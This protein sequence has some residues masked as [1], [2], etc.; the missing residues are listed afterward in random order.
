M[1]S[2]LIFSK[3]NSIFSLIFFLLLSGNY[4]VSGNL[5]TQ[6][7]TTYTESAVYRNRRFRLSYQQVS[8]DE[9]TR[10]CINDN[11]KLAVIDSD[12]V[13]N[14]ITSML[15]TSG[16]MAR[17]Y[18]NPAHVEHGVWFG[19]V[20]DLADKSIGIWSDGS[21]YSRENNFTKWAIREPNTAR[22]NCT[23][24]WRAYFWE[25]DDTY[26]DLHRYY[27]CED[28]DPQSFEVDAVEHLAES[29]LNLTNY[30]EVNAATVNKL[31]GQLDTFLNI[32]DDLTRSAS[33]SV[34]DIIKAVDDIT[35]VYNVSKGEYWHN[36]QNVGIEIVNLRKYDNGLELGE[37][38]TEAGYTKASSVY[39]SK[40][41]LNET[42]AKINNTENL[43]VSAVVFRKPTL[44]QSASVGVQD[45]GENRQTTFTFGDKPIKRSPTA[46]ISHVVSVDVKGV[47]MQN[48]RSPVTVNHLMPNFTWKSPDQANLG[49][50]DKKS[51]TSSGQTVYKHEN[52]RYQMT[53]RCVFWDFRMQDGAGDWS[54]AGCSRTNI[55]SNVNN[56]EVACSCN[57]MT[58]FAVI[59][60]T[61]AFYAPEYVTYITIAGCIISIICLLATLVTNLAF[62]QLRNK[63]HQKVLIHI[64][65]SLLILNIAFLIGID[66]T[67]EKTFCFVISVILHYAVLLSW[68][69]MLAEGV[70]LFRTLVLSTTGAGSGAC[71]IWTTAA[72]CYIIPGVV[73]VTVVMTSM[74]GYQSSRYCW[75]SQDPLLYS[76]VIP[77]G[78]V[79]AINC[80]IFLIIMYSITLRSRH[81]RKNIDKKR[82]SQ[83]LKRALCVMF[84]LGLPWVFGYIMLLV[85]DDQTKEIFSVLFTV[86]NAFQ[87]FAIFILYCVRQESVRSL[88]LKSLR[89]RY[90]K[91]LSSGRPREFTRRLTNDDLTQDTDKN[92]RR[93]TLSMDS[94]QSSNNNFAAPVSNAHVVQKP[95]LPPKKK[96][97]LPPP[98]SL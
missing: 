91:S 26:C 53:L 94:Y 85:N 1:F 30:N 89:S 61:S 41:L 73:V 63:L 98:N 50:Q 68:A 88:W 96:P 19:L 11:A 82:L 20:L 33:S 59:L 80:V 55:T 8:Y 16:I 54:D 70:F 44:F 43:Q 57:H 27:I 32:D 3:I 64:S 22:A 40:N 56:T 29:I 35:N 23:Q 7:D 90:R 36:R 71:F 69:W 58:H 45:N 92:I 10:R 12:N 67:E 66:K 86:F 76:V 65:I 24:L 39:L 34:N 18:V 6:G 9:A 52:I 17:N 93:K 75:L 49:L 46:V 13:S 83:A 31:A 47:T 62:K 77:V 79:L 4:A 38:R 15:Q 42:F 60:D 87:G 51:L 74:T 37:N 48:L 14:V 97:L 28:L 81:F 84:V 5:L 95:A 21:K 25:W 72:L 78:I 2:L